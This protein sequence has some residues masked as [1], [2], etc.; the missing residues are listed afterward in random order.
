MCFAKYLP[1]RPAMIYSWNHI[2]VRN[3]IIQM[4]LCGCNEFGW[5]AVIGIFSERYFK[6][7][8]V[9]RTRSGH[10]A[11]WKTLCDTSRMGL[12]NVRHDESP[13][14]IE[15]GREFNILLLQYYYVPPEMCTCRKYYIHSAGRYHDI[16]IHI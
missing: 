5:E 11:R 16:F 6:I 14:A 7:V 4:I 10:S 3:D 13:S 8:Y 2:F 9:T 15:R 12:G 1:E